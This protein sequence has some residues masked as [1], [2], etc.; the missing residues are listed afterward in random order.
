MARDLWEVER[1]AEFKSSF[2]SIFEISEWFLSLKFVL[3]VWYQK[4]VYLNYSIFPKIFAHRKFIIFLSFY[5]CSDHIYQRVYSQIYI[6][7]FSLQ[8]SCSNKIFFFFKY[9]TRYTRWFSIKID[10]FQLLR[11]SRM[12]LYWDAWNFWKILY[13]E[14][15]FMVW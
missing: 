8:F 7:V 10:F 6:P 13:F 1:I 9:I 3:Y 2:E 15:F 12:I 4:S 5:F 11:D 14:I